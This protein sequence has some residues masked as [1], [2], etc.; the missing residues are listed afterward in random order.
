MLCSPSHTEDGFGILFYSISFICIN[1]LIKIHMYS[2]VFVSD[3]KEKDEKSENN[4]RA[5]SLWSFES[6]FVN[7]MTSPGHK[8]LVSHGF[9]I[10]TQ[11]Y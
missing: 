2:Y 5:D 10:R 6:S 3:E 4:P 7:L 11:M 8:C 1:A 9:A